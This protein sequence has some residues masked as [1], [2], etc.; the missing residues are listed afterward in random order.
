MANTR[1]R[2]EEAKGVKKKEPSGDGKNPVACTQGR[3][4]LTGDRRKSNRTVNHQRATLRV[5]GQGRDRIQRPLTT[6]LW[7]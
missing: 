6:D 1:R 5:T 3:D 2:E 7:V 4:C